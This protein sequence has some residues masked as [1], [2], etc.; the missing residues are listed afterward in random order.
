LRNLHP[1]YR[2]A[3][4]LASSIVL[5]ASLAFLTTASPPPTEKMATPN[6]SAANANIRDQLIRESEDLPD[7][8]APAIARQ[9]KARCRLTEPEQTGEIDD[10][11]NAILYYRDYQGEEPAGGTP[12]TNRAFGCFY[13]TGRRTDF[14]FANI[15]EGES[16][17]T[18]KGAGDVVGF[19]TGLWEAAD[20]SND[21]LDL[22]NLRTGQL[23]AREDSCGSSYDSV[24]CDIV[25]FELNA[26][27]SFA[28]SA[29]RDDKCVVI[30]KESGGDRTVVDQLPA[31]SNPQLVV[32]N[33][34]LFWLDAAG[35]LKSS[36][37]K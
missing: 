4:L 20:G 18:A 28:Y 26:A 30:K 7:P 5:L 37:F 14:G 19:T 8:S 31:S 12:A 11:P 17:L 2:F 21:A 25:D 35:E 22:W 16:F 33:Q 1:T 36:S 13:A 34:R 6:L 15:V 10:A 23:L 27:G 32:R 3:A 9:D 29:C 24:D